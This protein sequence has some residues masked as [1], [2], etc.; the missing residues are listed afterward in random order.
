MGKLF[1]VLEAQ[2]FSKE[3][4]ENEFFPLSLEMEK[5]V[6][7][8]EPELLSKYS[9]SG[10]R[11]VRLF[12]E[13]STGTGFSFD[14]GMHRLGGAV[15]ASD[16][17]GDTAMIK[18]EALED[19][20]R[21]IAAFGPDVMV[22][23]TPKEGMAK[24]AAEYSSVPIINAGDGWGQ[25]PTQAGTDLFTV[26]KE[27]GGI[28]GLHYVI[29]GDLRGRTPRSLAY[30]VAKFPGIRITFVAPVGDQI[31]DDVKEYLNRHEVP[32][33]EIIDIMDAAPEGDV[34]YI[35]RIQKE[36]EK[37]LRS[38]ERHGLVEAHSPKANWKADQGLLRAIKKDAI[39]MH[40]LPHEDEIAPELDPKVCKDRRVAYLRQ[41]ENKLYV[42]MAFLYY[43]IKK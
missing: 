34:F 7:T 25:H 16:H 20:I 39:I 27:K 40:P 3:W 35:T 14:I 10:K 2:Q 29:A 38:V 4:L 8:G 13:P 31:G 5:L 26:K 15:F 37:L 9:L 22:L 43:A 36:R 41:S 24:L 42:A 6:K 18:G 32:F 21:R 30:L 19:M 12:W 28:E 17:A 1:H 33:K 23:R 11:M